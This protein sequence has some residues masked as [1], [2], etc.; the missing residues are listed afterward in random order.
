MW[1]INFFILVLICVFVVMPRSKFSCS[2]THSTGTFL[3]SNQVIGVILYITYI[4]INSKPT[5]LDIHNK[6]YGRS[7]EESRSS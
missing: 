6:N 2:S 5:M 3:I 1:E 7:K 4:I